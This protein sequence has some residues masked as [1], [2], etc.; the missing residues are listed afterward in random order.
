MS[1]KLLIIIFSRYCINNPRV[2]EKKF[3]KRMIIYLDINHID[4]D[5]YYGFTLISYNNPN[6]LFNF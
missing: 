2:N 1:V 6:Y 3:H 5:Q 4:L